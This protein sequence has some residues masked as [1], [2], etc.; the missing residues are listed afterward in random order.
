MTESNQ[1][2]GF[3]YWAKATL[4]F[5]GQSL[6]LCIGLASLVFTF[7]DFFEGNLTFAELSLLEI[8]FTFVLFSLI[9][10]HL[11][12]S[13]TAQLKWT[14]I[15][16]RPLRNIAWVNLALLCVA[17]FFILQDADIDAL[18]LFMAKNGN[19]LQRLDLILLLFCFY[20]AAPKLPTKKP[21]TENSG[22]EELAQ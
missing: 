5:L 9:G 21:I 18:N 22:N 8:L 4:L 6:L 14:S 17:L 13:K 1:P 20:C 11:T 7:V 19:R 2:K 16:Y 15:I 12:A 3:K 10:R